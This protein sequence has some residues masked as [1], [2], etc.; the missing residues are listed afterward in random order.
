MTAN[1]IPILYVHHRP[2]LG[3]APTSLHYLLRYLDRSRFE[4][5]VYCPPGPVAELFREEAVVHEGPVATLTHIWASTYS[6]R[7]WLLFGRELSQL[8]GHLLGFRRVLDARPF[9]L[10]HLNDSPLIPAAAVARSA[11]LPVVWHLRSALPGGGHDWRSR[12][13]RRAI[14]RLSSASIAISEDVADTFSVG[15][16]VVPNSIDLERYRPTNAADAKSAL[17]IS[18]TRPVVAYFGYIYPSKGF[19]DFI[20]AA[21][22][23]RERG[24]DALYLIVGGPVRGREFFETAVGRTLKRLDLVRDYE[25][26][27]ITL[28]AQRRLG[29]SVSFVP[30]RPDPALLYQA[31]DIVVAPSRGPEL[32][33]PVLEASACGR[34]IIASGSTNGAGLVLPDRTGILIP[35]RSPRRLAAALERL[36]RDETL[37]TRFGKNA[38]A[39]AEATFNPATNANRVMEVYEHV[40]AR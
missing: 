14:A 31:S 2:E 30:F 7:R 28:V 20:E 19:S 25:V 39:H 11:G 27:A 32:G 24:H 23:L 1:R 16:T 34:P 22:L 12:L 3:G 26:D 6:G 29:D 35:P 13:I 18:P 10:A 15:S 8:P 4:P 21:A 40:L 33:R 38:R 36:L 5:H 17:D 9:A 37:R